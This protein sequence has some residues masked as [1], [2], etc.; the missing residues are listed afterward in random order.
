MDRYLALANHKVAH[1]IGCI[2][3]LEQRLPPLLLPA[4]LICFYKCLALHLFFSP[5]PYKHDETASALGNGILGYLN[6]CLGA[7][8]IPVW[9][10]DK[11]LLVPFEGES[12]V[13]GSTP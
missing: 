13:L 1:A 2:W 7:M 6:L 3:G 5:L 8:V 10:Q 9:P 11:I 12:Y 4:C